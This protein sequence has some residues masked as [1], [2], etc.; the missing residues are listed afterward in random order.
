[1]EENFYGNLIIIG[2]AEDKEDKCEILKKVVREC[3]KRKGQLIV[4]TAATNYEDEVGETYRDVFKRLDYNNVE[5]MHILNRDDANSRDINKRIKE[6]ACIFFTGGDQLKI[7]SLIGGT[8]LFDSLKY[9][10]FNGSL[11]VGTSAGASCLCSTMIVSGVDEKSPRKCTIKMAPGMDLVRGV[12]IDQHFAQ[13]GRINRL[14]SAVAQNPD[15]LGIGIDENTAIFVNG[16]STFS[17]LGAGAVTIVDG[18]GITHTNVSELAPDEILAINDIRMHILPKG[19]KYDLKLK[20]P[21]LKNEE[22]KDENN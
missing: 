2:G 1:M 21:I 10:Y 13:R 11:I 14:I 20:H 6:S 17:V 12:L 4:L 8:C 5:V 7:T 22:E 3:E 19:Y 18:G 16:E 9:A 15:I